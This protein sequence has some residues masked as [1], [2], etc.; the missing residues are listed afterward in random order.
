VKKSKALVFVLAGVFSTD[1]RAS[2]SNTVL[3]PMSTFGGG[4]GW[5]AAGDRAYLT[6]DS[7]QRGLAYNL[8][9][10][11]VLLVSRAPSLAIRVLDGASGA[12]LGAMNTTGILG[13]I[14]SLNMISVGS[15]GYIYAANLADTSTAP[16][17]IYQWSNESVAPQGGYSSSPLFG[18]RLGDSLDVIGTHAH[19]LLVAGYGSSPSV[20]GN[21][22]YAVFSTAFDP[23]YSAQNIAFAG[24]PPDAGD[25][26]LG[27]TFLNDHT[28]LGS[29]GHNVYRFST[30][31]G[32]T[33]TLVAS[34]AFST[35]GERPMDYAIIN[36]LPLLAS[37][38]TDTSVVRVYD[39]SNPSAPVLLDSHTTTIGAA[40]AN[41]NHTGA[42][43]WGAIN[44]NS[45][46]LYV[47]NTNNGIEAFNVTVPE[48]ATPVLL[49]AAA[50][51]FTRRRRRAGSL[52]P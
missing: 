45:A 44:G 25:F 2:V 35:S 38:D 17:R 26:R 34:P 27:I 21:N 49:A 5:L 37:L 13:G 7:T 31:S 20:S 40:N 19:A 36:G 9:S 39:L 28:I 3:A 10:G 32:A 1:V 24:T 46:S 47:L 12:D 11:H 43:A 30:F 52:A 42:V 50:V 16:F 22:G 48:P 51:S 4:D 29:Q 15:D 6:T 23:P 8:A 14:F 41:A 18:A 33:G